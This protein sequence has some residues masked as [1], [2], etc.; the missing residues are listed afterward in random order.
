ME[1]AAQ[2][3]A[4]RSKLALGELSS[5]RDAPHINVVVVSRMVILDHELVD[6]A[7]PCATKS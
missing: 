1:A 5:E 7:A 3:G 6:D 2:R 4:K